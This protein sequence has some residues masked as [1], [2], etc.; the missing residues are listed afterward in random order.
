MSKYA[1]HGAAPL[2]P[3]L[4]LSPPLSTGVRDTAL[5]ARTRL[6]ETRKVLGRL[7]LLQLELRELA[8]ARLAG[9]E[10]WDEEGTDGPGPG[11][12]VPGSRGGRVGVEEDV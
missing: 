12:A 3:R 5:V 6:G 8:D 4:W 9:R 7:G 10:D 2:F 11:E 1:S